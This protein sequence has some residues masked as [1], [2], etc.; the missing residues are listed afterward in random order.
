[1]SVSA[2]RSVC[3]DLVRARW[4]EHLGGGQVLELNAAVALVEIVH[5]PV[6]RARRVQWM[7]D[8]PST[9]TR[10]SDSTHQLA[11][12]AV[13]RGQRSAYARD[14]RFKSHHGA[15][16]PGVNVLEEIISV[17]LLGLPLAH[18]HTH[19]MARMHGE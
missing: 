2:S 18:I 17:F 4:R 9:C 14:H 15:H 6:V 10:C 12:M 16:L 19:Q 3:A 8:L 1:M 7:E 11:D 5:L 13:I